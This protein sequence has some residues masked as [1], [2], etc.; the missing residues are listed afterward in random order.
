M[1]LVK[2]YLEV[3]T[4]VN[5]GQKVIVHFNPQSLKVHYE[6]SG[7]TGSELLR[8]QTEEQGKPAQPTGF[9]STLTLDLVFDTTQNGQDVRNTTLV[10]AHMLQPARD[11]S[12]P[13]APLGVSLVRFCWG[14][15][16]FN[17][18]ITSMDETLD[19]F[20]EQGIPLRATV[21]LS[22]NSVALDTNTTNDQTSS[23]AAQTNTGVGTNAL[24]LSQTGDSVQNLTGRAGIGNN[25]PAVASANNIENPRLLPTG[26]ILDLNVLLRQS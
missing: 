9:T 25:W 20:S 6:T 24:T 17:G 2:A 11:N 16:L 18:N 14:S 8:Q 7:V 4:G 26:T 23:T 21:N 19:F 10:L 3:V 13:K 12:N 22:M 5:K 15:F 1:A